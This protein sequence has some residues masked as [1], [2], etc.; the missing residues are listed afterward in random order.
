MLSSVCDG[1]R[2]AGPNRPETVCSA[3]DSC[4][5]PPPPPV[6]VREVCTCC[7]DCCHTR[8][9]TTCLSTPAFVTFIDFLSIHICI[10]A[11]DQVMAYAR[12]LTARVTSGAY[13]PAAIRPALLS[14]RCRV[15]TVLYGPGGPCGDTA[16]RWPGL[17][18][19]SVRD[20]DAVRSICE[21]R[22]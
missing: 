16:S 14:L 5:P 2:L 18:L 1:L 21:R 13:R 4:S 11:A 12:L 17:C 19:G 6:T 3:V 10:E 22:W 9:P 7:R 15:L 8:P 20:R